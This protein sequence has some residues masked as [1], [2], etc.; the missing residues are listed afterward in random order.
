MTAEARSL[1]EFAIRVSAALFLILLGAVMLIR[2]AALA[3]KFT[4]ALPAV[5]GQDEKSF[6][7]RHNQILLLFVVPGMVL[8]VCGLLAPWLLKS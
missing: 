1:L 4:K 3:I 8:M 2:G 6:S 7:S 5:P